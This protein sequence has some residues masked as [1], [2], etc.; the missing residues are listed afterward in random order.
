MGYQFLKYLHNW[1][2]GR[3][4]T[5]GY[6]YSEI[7]HETAALKSEK[8]VDSLQV[9]YTL[10][11]PFAVPIT[12]YSL[13][14]PLSPGEKFHSGFAAG[15]VLASLMP[16]LLPSPTLRC[17]LHNDF[18]KGSLHQ[19]KKARSFQNFNIWIYFRIFALDM[20]RSVSD[21]RWQGSSC[22]TAVQHVSP[23]RIQKRDT[24]FCFV[25]LFLFYAFGYF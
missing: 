21:V 16:S 10:R 19:E 3:K 20:F 12:K 17:P 15:P 23:G 22:L 6:I 4:N 18:V 1:R 2:A 14:D 25:S 24:G 8:F 11:T 13:K 5:M 7:T 9:R